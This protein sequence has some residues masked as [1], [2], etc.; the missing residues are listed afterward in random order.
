MALFEEVVEATERK[1]PNTRLELTVASK[2]VLASTEMGSQA[3]ISRIRPELEHEESGKL[4]NVETFRA[5]LHELVVEPRRNLRETINAV[6]VFDNDI[7]VVVSG[8]NEKT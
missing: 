7:A 4:H 8:Q 3:T 1:V 2:R 5:V 6:C